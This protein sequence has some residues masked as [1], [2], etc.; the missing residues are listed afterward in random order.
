MSIKKL[1]EDAK[2]HLDNIIKTGKKD[3][4]NSPTEAEL[5]ILKKWIDDDKLW[6]T[7]KVEPT[8]LKMF[9]GFWNSTPIKEQYLYQNRFYF[10]KG[11]YSDEQCTLL[12]K[13]SYDQERRKFEKLKKRFE[14]TETIEYI[15]PRIPERVRI[16]VWRRDDGKCVT[17]GS[18]EKLEYDHIIPISKG[19][20]NTTRNIEL[21]CEKCN[22][23]KSDKIQ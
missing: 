22:R 19:G 16:E 15:R 7:S 12:V 18:R 21:L 2:G 4:L 23:S 20:S 10:V 6:E 5:S 13:D 1:C 3:A 9:I 8:A 11:E 14:T 17:C